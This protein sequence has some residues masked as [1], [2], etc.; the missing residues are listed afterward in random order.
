MPENGWTKPGAKYVKRI[1]KPG[2]GW[3]Y[4]Y[5]KESGE[6][7]YDRAI[8]M[9]YPS[10]EEI[11]SFEKDVKRASRIVKGE[12]R[13]L[14]KGVSKATRAL[15]IDDDVV[16]VTKRVKKELK[17]DTKFQDAKKKY[18][19]GKKTVLKMIKKMNRKYAD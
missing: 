1:P 10:K 11:K 16:R 9:I 4:I 18:R 8:R 7:K 14:K 12:T 6:G 2:G 3:R 13:K 15:G 17:G 19:K 5:N